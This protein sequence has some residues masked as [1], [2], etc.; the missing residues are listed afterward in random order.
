MLPALGPPIP[1]S[2]KAPFPS[3]QQPGMT[4]QVKEGVLCRQGEL[5]WRVR[6][7]RLQF[8]PRLLRSLEFLTHP[9]EWGFVA[10]S[11]QERSLTL[12]AGQLAFTVCQTPV[13]YHLADAPE[14]RHR[15]YFADGAVD[16]GDGAVISEA[17][18]AAI[19]SR[20]GAVTRLEVDVPRRELA[21]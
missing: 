2:V 15:V 7:G 16:E 10:P 17:V 8:A 14:P 1:P 5:G 6:D 21:G 12:A 9:A 20:D 4:G 18:S 19:F 13:V 11:G 3:S